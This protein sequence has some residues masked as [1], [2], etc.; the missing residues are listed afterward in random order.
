MNMHIG[1]NL[2]RLRLAKGVTQE[3]LAEILGVSAQAVSRWE[4]D[5]SYPDITL[6][7]GIAM[8]Y[9]VSIDELIGMD[10]IRREEKLFSI[11]C[12]INK[13]VI[14]G[15]VKGAIQLIRDSL[16]IFPGDSGLMMSLGET[17]AHIDDE[18]AVTEAISVGE[19]V[20]TLSDVSMKAKCTTTVNLIF[21]C[22]KTGREADAAKLIKSLPHIWEA[23]EMLMPEV[24]SEKEYETELKKA[25]K[26]A[27]VFLCG[28]ISDIENRK[29]GE[30]P[31][32]VQLGVDFD[33]EKTT[34]EMLKIISDF[35]TE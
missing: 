27:L 22:L 16:K 1:K 26:K 32:Y 10:D 21:L 17:L 9:G 5:S 3:Q 24:Y 7:P 11:H 13:L 8:Y 18:S 19:K 28:K 4:N 25:I 35:L 31:A 2:K 29:K 14:A 15:D 33:T 30:M 12:D 23:R 6:L 20:L 34:G